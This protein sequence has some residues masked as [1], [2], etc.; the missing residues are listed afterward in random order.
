MGR[1]VA[2]LREELN[3]KEIELLD[4]QDSFYTEAVEASGRKKRAAKLGDYQAA[5]DGGYMVAIDTAVTPELAQEGMARELVHRIQ[6]MRRAAGF[7]VTD[8]IELF[9]QGPAEVEKVLAGFGDYV[10]LETLAEAVHEGE[11]VEGAH[12]ESHKLEG[13]DLTLGVRRVG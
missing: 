7:E 6:N 2:Q 5:L 9:Y 13:M 3:I 1:I 12:V 10:R 4:P 11:A 8:R